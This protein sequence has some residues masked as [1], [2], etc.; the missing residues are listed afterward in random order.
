MWQIKQIF[1]GV[2]NLAK[3][4]LCC[5]FAALV[6]AMVGPGDRVWLSMAGQWYFFRLRNSCQTTQEGCWK[7]QGKPHG[8]KAPGSEAEIGVKR[9]LVFYL[10][11]KP[12]IRTGWVIHEYT[13]PQG[14]GNYVLCRL[15]N[16]SDEFEFDHAPICDQAQAEP[17][18][19]SCNTASN[20]ENQATAN[21]MNAEAEENQ[22][23]SKQ[24]SYH[25]TLS[26]LE[27]QAAASHDMI[28]AAEEFLAYKELLDALQIPNENEDAIVN[29]WQTGSCK[30]QLSNLVEA[31]PD[32]YNSSHSV[33]IA[34]VRTNMLL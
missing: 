30:N 33:S 13:L 34:E 31:Q 29:G 11:G 8:I 1:S 25:I 10:H 27:I 19:G 14:L 23:A 26:P 4:C 28:T 16:K 7:Q 5:I 24:P 17:G 18:S 20:V 21:G 32:T 9:I 12:Q 15:R 2:Y 22:P 6:F 3:T